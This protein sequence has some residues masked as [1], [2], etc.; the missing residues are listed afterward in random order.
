MEIA[1]SRIQGSTESSNDLKP[2]INSWEYFIC[3]SILLP[4]WLGKR[5][6]SA[7]REGPAR[8][9][10]SLA[11][12]HLEAS[13]SSSP[14]QFHAWGVLR[15]SRARDEGQ[16][17]DPVPWFAFGWLW[18]W[19]LVSAGS[20]R[21]GQEEAVFQPPCVSIPRTVGFLTSLGTEIGRGDLSFL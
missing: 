21:F 10:G 6:A 2:A 17:G 19:N 4:K 7:P 5:S 8:D 3:A 16:R 11:G 13:L 20:R 18:F 9:E 1:A 14:S 15:T 12:Y